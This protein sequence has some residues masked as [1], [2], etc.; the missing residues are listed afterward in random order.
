MPAIPEDLLHPLRRVLQTCRE[1]RNI[2]LLYELFELNASLK[3]FVGYIK[4]GT[5]SIDRVDLNIG[6]A[7]NTAHVAD[8]N[9]L[10]IML[11][12]LAA[13][14]PQED[15]RR[16]ALVA[17]T[18]ALDWAFQLPRKPAE[19]EL[20]ANPGRAAMIWVE[21]IHACYQ[22]TRAVARVEVP[23]IRNG[24][25][26]DSVTGTAWLITP[27]LALT[28]WHVVAAS[29]LYDMAP[30]SP[31]DLDAQI[32]QTTLVFDYTAAAKG[33]SYAVGLEPPTRRARALDYVVL[34]L[35]PRADFPPGA[36]GY[37][38]LDAEAPLH[39]QSILYIIQH[40][41][42]QPQQLTGDLFVRPGSAPGRILYRTPTE[43][44]TSGAPV[45]GRLNWRVVALHTGENNAEQLRDGTH[46]GAILEDLKTERRDLFDEISR[47]QA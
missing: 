31:A 6:W 28:C 11:R 3:P 29:D 10:V 12:A 1:F 36:H 13:R 21:D 16:V 15:D 17:L 4:D 14:Y 35:Q 18:E 26:E 34:R 39:G 27:E 38:R 8:G 25:Q 22:A 23:R 5:S 43:H 40:P 9:I 30:P 37:L 47:A 2:E 19:R 32:A 24:R 33:V 20:Q 46:I 42:G 41:L 7:S 44:G 45:C